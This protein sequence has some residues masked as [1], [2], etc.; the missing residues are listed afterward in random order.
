M[1][2]KKHRTVGGIPGEV[3]FTG[4]RKVEKVNISY[5]DY[6]AD[7]VNEEELTNRTI[8]SFHNP[9][10][11]KVQ[12]YDIRGLHDTVLLEEIGKTFNLHPLIVEDI[13]DVNQRTKMEEYENGIY[14]K[15]NA[16]YVDPDPNEPHIRESVSIFFGKNFV[17]SFQEREYD[18]FSALRERLIQDK[19]RIR[20]RQA[21]YL[22]YALV[23]T[24][25]DQYFLVLDNIGERIE[26]IELLISK[27][28]E[29][30]IKF[31]IHKIKRE[32]LSIRKTIYPLRESINQLIK[33]EQDIIEERTKLFYRDI[34]D[35]TIETMDI[36]ETQRDM[37][38]GLQDL[39]ISEL[40]LRMNKVM[41]VLTIVT[42][43]FVPLTFLAGIYGMNFSNMPELHYQYGYYIL[44]VVMIVIAWLLFFYFKRMKWM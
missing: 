17:L 11:D 2:K 4:K 29:D 24:V 26:D 7:V 21:D 19:G 10:T 18:L 39:Y 25:V 35:H 33:S 5:L 15:I 3:V 32:I 44:L 28:A 8:K 6:N 38:Y 27:N 13:A 9:L 42:T 22:A 23:D 1:A 31:D 43:I 14:F 20:R 40:S 12:W 37:V 41:Q 34:Y 30:S 36:I 16:L